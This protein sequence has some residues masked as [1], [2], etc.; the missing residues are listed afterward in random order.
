MRK[1]KHS[2]PA[3]LID[4]GIIIHGV[5]DKYGFH[6]NYGIPCG[7]STQKIRK[8]DIGV[9]L[10]YDVNKAIELT[11]EYFCLKAVP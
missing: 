8:K 1:L 7:F 10:F 11:A 3:Y 2:R 6:P 4:D 5:K 9:K